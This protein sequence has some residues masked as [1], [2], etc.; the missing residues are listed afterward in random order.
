MKPHHRRLYDI[1]DNKGPLS[2]KQIGAITGLVNSAI[3]RTVGDLMEMGKVT[4]EKRGQ[5]NY[6]T[7]LPIEDDA[8]E[9]PVSLVYQAIQHRHVLHSV[10]A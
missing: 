3:Y 8:I 4:A 2:Q 10:W 5:T 1:L 6:Y 7:A 9:I